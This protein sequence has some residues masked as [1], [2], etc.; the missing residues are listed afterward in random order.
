MAYQCLL[1]EPMAIYGVGEYGSRLRGYLKTLLVIH[2]VISGA[3]LAILAASAEVAQLRGNA[4]GLPGA[5]AGI[6]IAAPCI[7]LFWLARRACYLD[8]RSGVAASGA[9]LYC[10]SMMCGLWVMHSIGALSPFSAFV[11]MGLSGLLTAVVL[12]LLL[13]S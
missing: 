11:M 13:H 4:G 1:L 10:V 7:L 3:I 6:G 9:V 12:F 2:A 5:L 8:A